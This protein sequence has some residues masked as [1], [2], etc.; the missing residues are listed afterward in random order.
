NAAQAFV[1]MSLAAAAMYISNDLV[2]LAADR[3]HRSKSQRPLASGELPFALAIGAIPVLLAAAAFVALSLSRE[4][5]LWIAV[6]VAVASG[7]SLL[8]KRLAIIDVLVL[9]VLYTVRLIAGAAAIA[10]PMSS[11]LLAFSMFFFLS[12]ALLKRFE[13]L[14]GH[15]RANASGSV[16]GYRSSDLEIVAIFGV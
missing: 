3:A 10:V 13:E 6:Y 7:Y 4:F 12:L 15:R 16:R 5:L 1:A 14:N 8:L 9:A 11:W 2:D